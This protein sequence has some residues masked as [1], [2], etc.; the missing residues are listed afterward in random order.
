MVIRHFILMFIALAG[1]IGGGI[2]I[3]STYGLTVEALVAGVIGYA[4]LGAVVGILGLLNMI[5][6][7]DF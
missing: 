5:F 3:L 6:S 4:I 2:Y 1:T 7:S